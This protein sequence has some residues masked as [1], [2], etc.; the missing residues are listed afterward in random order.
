[1]HRYLVVAALA[2]LFAALPQAASAAKF[3]YGVSSAEVSRN[4][5]LLWTR[6]P[7]AGKL[8]LDVSTS[9]RFTKRSTLHRRATASKSHDLTVRVRVRGLRAG[10]VYHY[11]FR[12]GRSKSAAGRLRTAPTPSSRK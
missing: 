5:A 7:K 3:K 10:R 4:G 6:A 9:S 11:R 12:Q 2:A 1:M 8:S